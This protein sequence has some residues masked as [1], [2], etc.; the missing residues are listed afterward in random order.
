[1]S[2]TAHAEDST[3]N[4]S[5]RKFVMKGKFLSWVLKIRLA[6]KDNLVKLVIYSYSG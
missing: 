1:M 5:I 2:H 4:S 6:L 3:I